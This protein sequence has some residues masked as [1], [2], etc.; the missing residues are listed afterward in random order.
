MS[1]EELVDGLV[2]HIILATSLQ[3]VVQ[4][5]HVDH[6]WPLVHRLRAQN[7]HSFAINE[8]RGRWYVSAFA[9][10]QVPATA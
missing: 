5:S 4:A 7:Y 1:V 10:V 8:T 2:N 3:I 6:V 9:P